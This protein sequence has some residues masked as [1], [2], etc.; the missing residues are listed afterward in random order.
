MQVKENRNTTDHTSFGDN[1]EQVFDAKRKRNSQAAFDRNKPSLVR[2]G[3]SAGI[4]VLV[5]LFSLME[6]SRVSAV[7]VSGNRYLSSDTIC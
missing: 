6:E 4:L 7:T 2:W 1:V 3:I 5:F